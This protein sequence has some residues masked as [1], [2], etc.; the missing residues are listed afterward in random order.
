MVTCKILVELRETVLI[1]N[2]QYEQGNLVNI[3]WILIYKFVRNTCV[4]VCVVVL[5]VRFI[6]FIPIHNN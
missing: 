2:F 6:R 4:Y 5:D 1:N 3:V